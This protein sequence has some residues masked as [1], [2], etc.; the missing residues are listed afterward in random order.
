MTYVGGKLSV[1]FRDPATEQKVEALL[2]QMTLPEKLGQMN[3]LNAGAPGMED[4]IKAGGVGSILNVR[5]GAKVNALQKIAVEESRLKIPLIAGNDVIHGYKTIFPIPLGE[6]ASWDLDRIERAAAVAAKEASAAGTH[7]TFAP[8]VDIARDPR[9]GRIAEGAGE[10]VYLGSAIARAR[11]KGFQGAAL[12]TPDHVAACAKHFVAYGAAE[13]GRDYN[14]TDMS[15]RVLEDVYL[16]PFHA[17]LDAGAATVMSAFNDLN[18]VP[19]SCNAFTLT[20]VLRTRWGFGGFVV[21]DWNSIGELIAHGAAADRPEAGKRALLAGVDMDMT[22]EIYPKDLPKLIERGEIPLGVVDEAVRRILRIKFALGLFER[23]YA[24]PAKEGVLLA[25]EHL[26]LARDVAARSCV[27]LKNDKLLPLR[28]NLPALAVLGPLAENR[29]DLL[30][31]WSCE[32][33]AKDVVTILEGIKAA[34]PSTKVLHARGC[35]I[36]Q[37]DGGVEIK[38]AVQLARAAGLAL[39]VLGEEQLMSGEGGSRTSLGLPGRQLELAQAVHASGIPFIAVVLSGR[40]LAIPW[41]AEHAGAILAAWHPGTQG[42]HAVADVLFGDV[43]PSAK[44]PVCWPVNEGQVPVYY[45]R[46]ATG[47]P[48][49]VEERTTSKYLDAPNDP[50]YPFGFGLSYTTFEYANLQIVPNKIERPANVMVSV[51]VSN[52]GKVAGEETVQLYL[53]DVACTWTRPVKE[54]VG[55]KKIA[56]QP[57]ERQSV[58]FTITPEQLG[59]L[60]D[61]LRLHV[62]PGVF[63][64]WA[65]PSSASGLEG[66]L[67]LRPPA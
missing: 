66:T 26:A 56:L 44:T 27:L 38:D 58:M 7:W 28:K 65:G 47:R 19:A 23:P 67:E 31:T 54:L 64:V 8:M 43:N 50:L 4:A 16:P 53:R 18:G 25:P 49:R 11:V 24:D 37:D 34:S 33:E 3:Q 21:S 5:G 13:G 59:V 40:P 12:G 55:F 52:T 10:D 14:T 29:A 63:T 48:P 2:G 39:F 46:K 57:G 36:S 60:D 42:G 35:P 17:A 6:A 20:E 15:P 1:T 51:D 32:G 41:L 30:G 45:A 9:W 22:A 62:E 61:A